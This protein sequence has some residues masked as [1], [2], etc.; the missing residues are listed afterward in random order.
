VTESNR[1]PGEPP[2][3]NDSPAAPVA[4]AGNA[5][6]PKPD[7]GDDILERNVESLLSR[8]HEPPRLDEAARQR[9]R[10]ALLAQLPAD[11]LNAARARKRART[12]A[13][14]GGVGAAVA[15]AAAVAMI[16]RQPSSGAGQPSDGTSGAGAVAELEVDGVR[17]LA[18]GSTAELS[19]GATLDV[20]GP[21][22]VRVT[23]KV[24]LDVAPGK[25]RFVVETASGV[26]EALGTR[27][28][29]EAEAEATL[30]AVIRGSIALSSS[31]RDVAIL[32]N[33]AARAG[34]L[35]LGAGEGGSIR[36]G[37][38][39]QRQAVPRLSHLTSWVKTLRERQERAAE[40]PGASRGTLFARDPNRPGLGE[41]PL[42]MKQ[43][44]VD[45]VVEHRV[46]RVAIDHTFFNPNPSV[47]E[48]NY[49]FAIP[50]DAALQ[51]FAMY[52]DGKLNEAAVVE[53]MRA[54]R[55][56]EDLVYVRQ[57][58]PALL[59]YAGVGKLAMRVYPLPPQQDKRIA[60]A[61][62]QTLPQLYDTWT[63][64]VPLP[65]IDG[66]VDDVRFALH[67]GD[68]ANCEVAS[69]SHQLKV[70]RSGQTLELSYAA[71]GAPAGDTLL[72]NVRERRDRPSVASLRDGDDLY[73]QVRA[74]AELPPSAAPAATPAPA[75]AAA[76]HEPRHWIILNDVSASRGP[77][78]RRAQ[79]E[80]AGAL[81]GELDEEDQVAVLDFDVAVRELLPFQRVL[82][83]DRDALARALR[84]D[85]GGVGA[86]DA[87]AGLDAALV[88]FTRAGATRPVILYLGDGVVTAGP[89]QLDELRARLTGQA[90]KPMFVGIGLGEGPDTLT[91]GS[92]AG[93]TGGLMATID[94]SDD[95]RWRAFDLIATL[96][97]PRITG[98]TA[99]LY[100]A[101]GKGLPGALLRSPQL[102]D[103]EELEVV[104]RLPAATPASVLELR[105]WLDGAPWNQRIALDAASGI[106]TD[107]RAGY[108]PRLWAQREIE[109]LLLAKQEPAAMPPCARQ[110]CPSE[111]EVREQRNEQLRLQIVELGKRFFLLSRHTS[112]IV[113]END[114]MYAEYG[115]K[116]GS[117]QT[118][119]P[120]ALPATIPVGKAAPALTPP[121]PPSATAELMRDSWLGLAETPSGMRP[122]GLAARKILAVENKSSGSGYG[123]IG[124]G[125][126][127][128][129]GSLAEGAMGKRGTARD[130]EAASVVEADKASRDE[131]S[132][133]AELQTQAGDDGGERARRALPTGASASSDL[134]GPMAGSAAG[135]AP[136]PASAPASPARAASV[137]DAPAASESRAVGRSSGAVGNG[138][139]SR[140]R[141]YYPSAGL[142]SY[143]LPQQLPGARALNRD[144]LE[145]LTELVPALLRDELVVALETVREARGGTAPGAIP[146]AADAAATARLDRVSSPRPAGTYRRG[147]AS[148]V[149]DDA[150]HLG[151]K[152]TLSDGLEETAG[153]DGARLTRRYAELGLQVT[154]ELRGSDALAISLT[155]FPLWLPPAEALRQSFAVAMNGKD[156]ITLTAPDQKL[157]A[158]RFSLDGDRLRRI[159]DGAGH[160]LAE[161]TWNGATPVTATVDGR[162][163]DLAF[164]ATAPAA[165]AGAGDAATALLGA[166]SAPF[167][168][169]EL[170]LRSPAVRAAELEQQ[171]AG[172]PGWRHA[173]HQL[174]ASHGA[175]RSWRD[176][177]VPGKAL[178]ATGPLLPG[179]QAL[180]SGALRM[181]SF[182]ERA[183]YTTGDA[184]VSRYLEVQRLS[185]RRTNRPST[186]PAPS[187]GR[188]G[189]FAAPPS[190]AGEAAMPV[191]PPPQPT[192]VSGGALGALTIVRQAMALADAG[193]A[194]AALVRASALP[195]SA[196][197]W[198]VLCATTFG[199]RYDRSGRTA[200][201]AAALWSSLDGEL[202]NIGRYQAALV[203]LQQ[204]RWQRADLDN[205]A[206]QLDA[207]L[208]N[209]DLRALPPPVDASISYWFS[210]SSRGVAGWR[211]TYARW[212]DRVLT[213][214]S[215][216]HVLALLRALPYDADGDL[217]RI[218]DRAS[219]LAG[220][221]ADHVLAIAVLAAA[222]G[223]Q[224][225][226]LSYLQPYLDRATA[227]LTPAPKPDP[228]TT[229]TAA[230]TATTAAGS[231]SPASPASP[232]A[233]NPWTSAPPASATAPVQAP[234]QAAVQAAASPELARLAS[235][236]A[237]QL[238]QPTA[239]LDSLQV[240]IALDGGGTVADYARLLQLSRDIAT[241]TIP[242]ERPP[243]IARAERWARDWRAAD[244]GGASD[245]LLAQ[246]LFS[247]GDHDGAFR[248]LSSKI[249]RDPMSGEAWGE[250]AGQFEAAGLVDRSLPYWHEALILDQTNP[251]WRVRNARALTA[252]GRT[253][254]AKDILTEVLRRRWH[255]RWEW[256]IYEA[257]ELARQLGR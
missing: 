253:A 146:T 75:T 56:Y 43:L 10:G 115:V 208:E 155:Y 192:G 122:T 244:P 174:L 91:L 238:G 85:D 223:Q 180:L 15:A 210:Q 84:D 94:L 89:R 34:E 97:T 39:P 143:L 123:T 234:V 13:V 3:P 131:K 178:V 98:L 194:S 216:E 110:P 23:G 137:A 230:T 141:S 100:D 28:V 40:L 107:D 116:K 246:L 222:R 2:V 92:L 93:A 4:P 48:G 124:R 18:D 252:V 106:P 41:S 248:V 119:A 228:A 125:A 160:V 32:A 201:G 150:H 49:R 6:A 255:A 190:A 213:G 171:A 26:V 45:V 130:N 76:R 142:V 90:V 67:L 50:P 59:E 134:D 139:A 135:P 19:P 151:W 231:A 156:E 30:A 257:R 31:A 108:A 46:A 69:P 243:V 205:A 73:L 242:A 147:E 140:S 109:R 163:F 17:K 254:E 22:R 11:D 80:L 25:G 95:L 21:R 209:L 99:Q 54:R 152:R 117:G 226:A 133:D 42:P 168:T 7:G 235:E 58:D 157:P 220:G 197:L 176:L 179:E 53:R 118:W 35:V 129:G 199:N 51:R 9:I 212:R 170:P 1:T 237:Q 105:G 36:R 196:R 148:F 182:E 195:A 161:I 64:A 83:V 63:L 256:T 218:L 211:A 114:A 81:I 101:A 219:A 177:L 175:L 236:L 16:V 136:A 185:E 88:R 227:Q 145:D 207:M 225:W 158:F 121:P 224:A 221:D 24:L 111:A 55:V 232:S 200:E 214:G 181:I 12:F 173:M 47:L 79:A 245:A 14:A 198:R 65:K 29:V 217:L 37:Q 186:G 165:A 61:Y 202:T 8:A 167:T 191:R 71:Q 162:P 172:T 68:C 215:F 159:S 166:A 241:Q 87:A 82:G 120:Y 102:A 113:L 144:M 183:A 96:N 233:M 153:F 66:P 128:G 74:P 72:V 52:V 240:A 138:R 250:I 5:S 44:T 20:L 169:I 184:P 149:A 126:G 247:V 249:D 203:L 77:L 78:E 38:P 103:G 189:P 127:G 206:A 132:A 104:A 187:R 33:A 112:L 164:S 188:R 60:L 193:Q 27:F 57:V 62:T 204:S 70:A 251:T 86:T 154:S 229:T 239:A